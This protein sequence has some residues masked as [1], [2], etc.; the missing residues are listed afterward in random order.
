MSRSI[1]IFYEDDWGQ[2]K[3]FGL[4]EL[5]VACVADETG[6]DS[7]AL[8]GRFEAIPKKGDS[9]LLAACRDDVPNMPD[10]LIFALFD[11]D[12][13]RVLLSL[14]GQ[15]TV[16][17]RLAALREHCPDPRLQ[18]F[19]IDDNTETMVDAVAD[20][21]GVARP[22][23]NKLTRDRLLLRAARSPTSEVRNCARRAVP[24][25]DECVRRVAELTG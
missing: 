13:L 12:K 9:K 24:S 1:P 16:D 2:V 8:R 5:L 21:L 20:C 7:W 25:F 11:A 19:L 14:P 15:P 22:A 4:H 3:E 18:L 6:A 10:A 23:K 17:E